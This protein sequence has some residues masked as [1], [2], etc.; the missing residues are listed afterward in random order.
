MSQCRVDPE[1]K[2]ERAEAGHKDTTTI[3]CA[4][5]LY[6]IKRTGKKASAMRVAP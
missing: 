3:M 4:A 5:K 6:A 2:L 1:I